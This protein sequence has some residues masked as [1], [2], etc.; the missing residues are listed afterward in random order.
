MNDYKKNKKNGVEIELGTSIKTKRQKL[1]RHGFFLF[2]VNPN[3]SP[4]EREIEEQKHQEDLL[5]L[6][7]MYQAYHNFVQEKQYV[8]RG[9]KL[10]C[11][12]GT[13]PA[14]LDTLEDH[15]IYMGNIPVMACNDC[16]Q[17]NIHNFGSCMCPESMYE[18]RGLPM[19]VEVHQN[20]EVACKAPWNKRPHICIP[21]LNEQGE[22]I[23]EE[24]DLLIIEGE[25]TVETLADKATL[26]CR[27]GGIIFIRE[28]PSP[29]KTEDE[30]KEEL[31]QKGFTE[32]YI[33]H[34]MVLHEKYPKWKFEAVKTG[35]D[36]Q[37][38]VRYQIKHETKCAE[39][40]K[41]QTDKRYEIEKSDRYYV[42]TNEAITFFSHPYSMLQTDQGTYENALQFLKAEQ[43]ID[44][45]YSDE[46]VEKIL[47]NK[48]P[49]VINA[50]KNSN[51]SINPVFM[52]CIVAGE[53]GP[54][55]ESYR[56]KEVTNIFNFGATGGR[57]DGLEYA[58]NKG[59]FS[60]EA[61]MEGAKSEFQSFLDRHQ[62]TLYA[63]DWDFPSYSEGKAVRQYATLVN[64]AENKAIM[65]SKKKGVMF[66]LD[67]E[68]TFSIPIFEN[69]NTY[70]NE[71]CAPFPDPNRV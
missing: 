6:M 68:F 58:Y 42:A 21:L 20:G 54:V 70:N 53:G 62:D 43:K 35:V 63:L 13:K 7:A 12:Y 31:R 38:F 50:I 25:K 39:T 48:S 23:Q 16:K 19:T 8:L 26:T 60:I 44:E 56:G 17:A 32:C 30:F 41:Y 66:D 14:L 27:Y 64:D 55:E 2:Q 22:W 49:K 3:L 28:V 61:C 18:N 59:W 37:E 45:K 9:S 47:S 67:K 11:I 15:G 4:E 40:P 65:M 24:E 36:Y 29:P 1:D 57:D 10:S 34:L 5:E 46:V 33:K 71:P 52:A 69:I 51:C